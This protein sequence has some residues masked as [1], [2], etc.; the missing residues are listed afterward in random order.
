MARF[1]TDIVLVTGGARG[2]GR[3]TVERFVAEGASV[4]FCDL[5][6]DLGARAEAQI[7][8]RCRFQRC[9]L[10][11]EDQIAELVDR[12]ASE[13]GA[14]TILVNNA[15]INANFDSTQMTTQEWDAFFAVDLKAPWLTAKYVVP[16]M[17]AAGR[18]AIVNV[19]SIHGFTTLPG[20][21]PYG[22]A[23]SG[24]VGLTRNMA[25]DYG[26]HGIRVNVVCPGFIRTRLVQDSIDRNPDPVAAEA[27][28]VRAVALG[29]IAQA[30]E[31]AA[32][33]TF[34]GSSDASYITGASVLVDG[35][36]TARR[37]G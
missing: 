23:K 30:D 13:L 33:I 1:D 26:P 37:A 15:G 32:V 8:E 11:D 35:G 6:A 22:A 14:A 17:K 2:I 24:L 10:R 12:C 25:L 31:V 36:L 7:G 28:M 5:D 29:R 4:M 18:G 21:F 9:D 20:F 34:L 3:A 27:A 16:A 19:A